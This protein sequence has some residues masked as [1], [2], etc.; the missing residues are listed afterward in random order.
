MISKMFSVAS[1]FRGYKV[2]SFRW[3]LWCRKNFPQGFTLNEV[4]FT[5]PSCCIFF[6]VFVSM[7]EGPSWV[8]SFLQGGS[9]W[10]SENSFLE[11]EK[12]LVIWV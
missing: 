9:W 1:S 6:S 8:L 7:I 5:E 12:N 11:A 3:D 4:F 2:G 10:S